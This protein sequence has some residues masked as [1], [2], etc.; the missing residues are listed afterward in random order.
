MEHTRI[1]VPV[2]DQEFSSARRAVRVSISLT[3]LCIGEYHGEDEDERDFA[4]NT[5][6]E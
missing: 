4:K 6:V 5:K 2:G 1:L 3:T